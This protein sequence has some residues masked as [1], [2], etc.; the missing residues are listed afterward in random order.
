MNLSRAYSTSRIGICAVFKDEAP[1]I[2]EWIAYHWAIGF[3]YFVLYDNGSS[4][5][6]PE[7][8]AKSQ[9][10]RFVKL[11]LWPDRPGQLSAYRHFCEN[12]SSC[13]D[14]VAFIDIDEFIH[15]LRHDTIKDALSRYDDRSGVLVQWL[16]FGPSGHGLRPQGLVIENYTRRL[17]EW[18]P[19]CSW[20]KPIVRTTKNVIVDDTPHVFNISGDLCNTRNELVPPHA[21]LPECHDELVINH[22]YTK[23]TAD[24]AIKKK[25]GAAIAPDLAEYYQDSDFETHAASAVVSDQRILRFLPLVRY[26]LRGTTVI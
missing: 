13:F 26:C 22:Y 15:P 21:Q 3:E 12:F 23:S 8:I 6:G 18:H 10:A 9:L 17:Q 1:D 7:L 11:I 5:G 19:R 16:T 4:D 24:W 14:W 20:V 2:L 25:R